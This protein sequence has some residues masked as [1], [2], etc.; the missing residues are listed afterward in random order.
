M[1]LGGLDALVF[2]AGVGENDGDVRQRMVEG[3]EFMGIAIDPERNKVR[4]KVAEL[5]PEG[6]KVKVFMIP[7][8]EELVIARDTEAIVEGRPL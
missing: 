8:D 4:A 3:L 1:E 7:T 6:A 2:T 5:S